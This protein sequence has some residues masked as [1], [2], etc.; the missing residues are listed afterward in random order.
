MKAKS[1][2]TFHVINLPQW[3]EIVGVYKGMS[4]SGNPVLE[5]QG[6]IIEVNVLNLLSR[7]QL[8]KWLKGILEG[9]LIGIL[10][11]DSADSP[12][13]FRILKTRGTV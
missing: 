3:Q 13:L 11:T 12:I 6:R 9:S 4:Q 10:R 5:V 1:E 2:L 7:G 8:E